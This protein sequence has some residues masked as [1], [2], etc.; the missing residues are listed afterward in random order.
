MTAPKEGSK[1]IIRSTFEQDQCLYQ[2]QQ[3]WSDERLNRRSWT[4]QRVIDRPISHISSQ[5]EG[6]HWEN[7]AGHQH[8]GGQIASSLLGELRRWA[9]AAGCSF[10]ELL[11]SSG[12]LMNCPSPLEGYF[13]LR[14]QYRSS[15]VRSRSLQATL[16]EIF[17]SLSL[18]CSFLNIPYQLPYLSKATAIMWSHVTISQITACSPLATFVM[19]ASQNMSREGHLPITVT[20][21]LLPQAIVFSFL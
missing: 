13:S 7:H 9:R 21:D 2:F 6:P 19:A 4:H 20:Y 14:N 3:R 17:Q 12:C 8:S 10:R 11:S 15:E 16:E 5:Q 18:L 1:P